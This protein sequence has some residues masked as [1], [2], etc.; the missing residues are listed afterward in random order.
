[1]PLRVYNKPRQ[2]IARI[3]RMLMRRLSRRRRSMAAGPEAEAKL[4]ILQST[5]NLIPEKVEEA[6]ELMREM[7]RLCQHEHGCRIIG[8]SRESPTRPKSFCCRNG[9]TPAACKAITRRTTWNDSSAAWDR[10]CAAR[11]AP[12][13]TSPR[14]KTPHP[15]S[16]VKAHRK[17][18]RQ[19]TEYSPLARHF[20]PRRIQRGAAGWISPRSKR[21]K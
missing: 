20:G 1:M 7:M 17:P 9:T 14:T 16:P 11:S 19:F 3:S 18:I 13:A 12:E 4:I 8:T 10:C 6:L 5:F 21:L 2:L 15:T